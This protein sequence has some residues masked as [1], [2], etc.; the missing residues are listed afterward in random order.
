MAV[1]RITA[2]KPAGNRDAMLSLA[3]GNELRVSRSYRDGLK[4]VWTARK[5]MDEGRPTA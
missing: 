5:D 2:V 3:D 1:D 4:S